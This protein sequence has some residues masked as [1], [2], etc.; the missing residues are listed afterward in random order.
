MVE[1]VQQSTDVSQ[2]RACEILGQPQSTQCYAG[3]TD[4]EAEQRLVARMHELVRQ[5]PR[6]GYRMI[7][8]KLCQDG[9]QVNFNQIY[10]LWR[11]EGFRV[12]RKTRKKCWLGHSG[13]SCVRR[14]AKYKDH[15]WTWNRAASPQ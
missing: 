2:R 6:K 12:S 15:I 8:A 14:R 13:N 5:Y 1:H 10:R 11:R 7:T 4:T 9:W 3:K